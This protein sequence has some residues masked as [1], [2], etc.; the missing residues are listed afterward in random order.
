M[1]PERRPGE[2]EI[3]NKAGN[4]NPRDAQAPQYV[5][6]NTREQ[7]ANGNEIALAGNSSRPQRESE[8]TSARRENKVFAL[9]LPVGPVR[10]EGTVKKVV[11]P[12]DARILHLQL[13]LIGENDVRSYEA[14]LRADDGGDIK[15]WAGLRAIRL[16]SGRVVSIMVPAGLLDRGD[17][18]VALRG[19]ASSSEVRD[20][21]TYS[22]RV[23][24]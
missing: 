12:S 17:Y 15:T 20:I 10:G 22:F 21:G 3:N 14:T 8:K 9:L 1:T 6:R 19:I 18:S 4:S 24:K 7:S 16:K 13:A 5:A 11:L 23:Q 2:N